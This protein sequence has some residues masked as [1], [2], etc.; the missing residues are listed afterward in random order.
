M[1]MSNETVN[2][3]TH[4]LFPLV[5]WGASGHGKA[6]LDVAK[7][8]G[9]FH[10]ILFLDDA[11]NGVSGHYCGVPLFTPADYFRKKERREQ[12]LISIGKNAVR[13]ARFQDAL[14]NGMQPATLIHPSAIV[15]E[16]A[17]ILGGTVVM[18]RVVVNAAAEI[19]ENCILNTASVIEHDCRIGD[20]V[21]LS[22][23]V[24]LAGGV[25]VGAFAHLG[26]GAVVLP[27][28]EIGEGAVVG[29]GAVVTKSVPKDTTVVGI[30]ARPF[31]GMAI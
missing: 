13:A 2:R 14:N 3:D 10:E 4:D 1:R 30:P 11:H 24:L 16:S 22:P 31:V 26:I 21:H 15:S 6:V 20:H 19:G 5:L 25:Q 27:G 18:A 17:R 28:V 12:F 8:E 7:A 29:A 23:G 9:G